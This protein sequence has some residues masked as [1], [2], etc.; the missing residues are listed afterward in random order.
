MDTIHLKMKIKEKTHPYEKP[1]LIIKSHVLKW[2]ND[3]GYYMKGTMPRALNDA[4]IEILE[5]AI[6]RTKLSGR[7]TISERDV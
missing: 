6:I 7:K 1:V 4:V 3:K 2:I 5:K